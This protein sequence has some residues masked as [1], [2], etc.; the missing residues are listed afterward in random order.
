[1]LDDLWLGAA[2]EWQAR[3]HARLCGVP[4]TV[5]LDGEL[6]R[7]SDEQRTCVYRV[8]QEALNNVAKHSGATEILVE[9]ASRSGLLS[10]HVRDNGRGFSAAGN[11]AR[12][13]GI[14]GMKERA[15]QLGGYLTLESSI[16]HGVTI[17]AVIPLDG[18]SIGDRPLGDD[19][20]TAQEGSRLATER[21]SHLTI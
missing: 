12:G 6:N 13:L 21:P 20:A 10:I 5:N 9:V 2:L 3:Q 14:V 1:M 15:R 16:G 8:V 19:S 17:D 4:V 18:S 7:L 11:A